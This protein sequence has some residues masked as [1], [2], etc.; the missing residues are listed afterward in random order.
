MQAGQEPKEERWPDQAETTTVAS[1]SRGVCKGLGRLHLHSISSPKS[2]AE[3]EEAGEAGRRVLQA[4][5]RLAVTG[6]EIHD[7][8]LP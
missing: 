8:E 5:G 7:A 3:R 2:A 4:Q 6:C 1:K